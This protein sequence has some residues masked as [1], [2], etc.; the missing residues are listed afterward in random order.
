MNERDLATL[1]TLKVWV[2]NPKQ[3]AMWN[4]EE[5]LVKSKS[6]LFSCFMLLVYFFLV[7]LNDYSYYSD[8]TSRGGGRVSSEASCV[9]P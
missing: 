8:L 4:L 2:D 7:R 9:L 5:F 6:G 3:D 1:L